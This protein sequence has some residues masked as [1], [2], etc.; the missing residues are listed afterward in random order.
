MNSL[1]P[2]SPT[3][4]IVLHLAGEGTL[5]EFRIELL[6]PRQQLFGW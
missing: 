4:R 5:G 3:P 1:A 2:D 6:E